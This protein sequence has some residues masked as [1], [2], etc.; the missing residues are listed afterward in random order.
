MVFTH[1][2]SQYYSIQNGIDIS[3][4]AVPSCYNSNILRLSN[5]RN[6]PTLRTGNNCERVDFP[7]TRSPGRQLLVK[8]AKG[9]HTYALL[10]SLQIPMVNDNTILLVRRLSS[11]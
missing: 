1:A 6:V 11:E 8:F 10:T 4:V 2:N 3:A 9:S 5:Y 7:G